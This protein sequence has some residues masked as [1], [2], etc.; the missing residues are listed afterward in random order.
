M[1]D[2]LEKSHPGFGWKGRA[3]QSLE[4]MAVHGIRRAAEMDEAAMMIDDLGLP[5]RMTQQTVNWQN[6]VGNL[7]MAERAQ[8]PGLADALLKQIQSSKGK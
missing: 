2:S 8:L 4:R 6:Q 7:D 5:S 1:A 3:E